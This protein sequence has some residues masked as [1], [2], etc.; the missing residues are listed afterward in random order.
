MGKGWLIYDDGE[1]ELGEDDGGEESEDVY[2]E[3]WF[4]T[5]SSVRV[6]NE[7]DKKG[8]NEEAR[9]LGGKIIGVISVK[10]AVDEAP[11][12][13]GG[14]SDFDVLPGGFVDSGEEA[15]DFVFVA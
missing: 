6:K 13:G 10:I 11:D 14:D 12:E 8:E 15:E 7:G 2:G 5:D 4:F 3:D 1:G 9:E